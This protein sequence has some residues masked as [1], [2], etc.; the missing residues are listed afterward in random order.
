VLSFD[1]KGIATLH[2][3]L[4]E[5]T[6]KAAEQ[7]PDAWKRGLTKGEK[8]NRKRMA[9]VAAVYTIEQWPREIAERAPRRSRQAR[10]GEAEAT[11]DQQARVGERGVFAPA[12][13]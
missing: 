7:R 5:A 12:A 13:A 6:R 1:A 9:Q 4:R 2:R 3:D 10:Q 8:P 11:T